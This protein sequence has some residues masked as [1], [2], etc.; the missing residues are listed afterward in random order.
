MSFKIALK[1][2]GFEKKIF[3]KDDLFKFE[4]NKLRETILEKSKILKDKKV[5]DSDNFVLEL[6]EVPNNF[7]FELNSIWNTKTFNYLIEQLKIFQEN[8]P[9]NEIKFRFALSKVSK[10]PKWDKKKYD[11]YLKTTLENT[12]K[13]E[14]N[15]IISKLNN[16]EL[17]N[18]KNEF[19]KKNNKEK[20][21]NENINKNIIC[22]SCLSKDFLGPRYICSYCNNFNL[23]RKCFNL[24]SHNP[25]HNFIICKGPVVDDDIIKYNSRFSPCTDV[26]RNIYD[27]FEVTF[28]IAN[29][30]EKD[31]NK[32]YMTYINFNGNYLWCKKFIINENLERNNIS[33]IKLKINFKDKNENKNGI[34]EGHFRMFNQN[35]VPF[36]DI[37][38]IRVKNDKI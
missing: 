13:N 29:V 16:F 17:N 22:N 19:L 25:E 11:I 10:L 28:K 2:K 34:F 23:C 15:I 37:L 35:G 26:L 33:E 5:K 31:L 12:W 27:S 3:L 30:G 36:G 32:C 6:A 24:G 20:E 7:K 38:K 18:G 21:I 9:N 4:W 14:E 1:E 8:N